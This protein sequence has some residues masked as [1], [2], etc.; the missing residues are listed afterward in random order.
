MEEWVSCFLRLERL[1]LA[2]AAEEKTSGRECAALVSELGLKPWSTDS[3]PLTRT[4]SPPRGCR[5]RVIIQ[6]HQK[7]RMSSCVPAVHVLRKIPRGKVTGV[8]CHLDLLIPIHHLIHSWV[9]VDWNGLLQILICSSACGMWSEPFS[10]RKC[11]PSKSNA[12]LCWD[13]WTQI[14]SACS[15]LLFWR[16]NLAM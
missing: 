10:L 13:C 8:D 2:A 6:S 11:V 3:K 1:N 15:F 7:L 16:Q 4:I 12:A 14:P 5:D 9:T